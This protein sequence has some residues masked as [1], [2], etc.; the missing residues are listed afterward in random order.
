MYGI[1][2][3]ISDGSMF[4]GMD[5]NPDADK[6]PDTNPPSPGPGGT[7]TDFWEDVAKKYGDD[8]AEKL[9][10]FGEDGKRL[11]EQYTDELADIISRM[12]DA[13][14]KKAIELVN[15]YGDEAVNG[16]KAGKSIDNV[17]YDVLG[18]RQHIDSIIND[19]ES[20]KITLENTL[21]K[22]NY[23]E[24]KMDVVCEDLGY[25]RISLDRVSGLDDLGHHGIDGVYYNPK[26]T[27]KYIIAEAK[28]G[29]SQLSTLKDGTRQMSESG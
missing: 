1:P 20:G 12:S 6:N 24:M 10:P 22:G 26:G 14:A 25:Q 8:V 18:G 21:Q 5:T 11:I 16:L 28:Y 3:T 19:V 2:A 15:E 4:I 9:K 29:S 23:G 7:A 27:P 17:I 13:D